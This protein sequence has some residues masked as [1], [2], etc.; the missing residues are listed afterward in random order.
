MHSHERHLINAQ[1]IAYAHAHGVVF[2]AMRSELEIE[3]QLIVSRA[4]VNNNNY[5]TTT[6]HYNKHTTWPKA[7]NLAGADRHTHRRR[8]LRR[9]I[10]R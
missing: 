8:A 1:E 5:D 4:Q 7:H 2:A 3:Y 10:H 6:T 9:A